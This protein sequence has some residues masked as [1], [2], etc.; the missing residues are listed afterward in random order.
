MIN[1][2]ANG[3]SVTWLRRKLF[4]TPAEFLSKQKIAAEQ[5]AACR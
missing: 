2:I 4:E 5:V 1:T 3:S